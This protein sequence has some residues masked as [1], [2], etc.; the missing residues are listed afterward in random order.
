MD[1]GRGFEHDQI[2]FTSEDIRYTRKGDVLYAISLGW[3]EGEMVL[4]SP[5]VEGE[6]SEAMVTMLGCEDE[7]EYSV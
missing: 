7:I 3:P 2:D 6:S 5:I 1:E 4:S